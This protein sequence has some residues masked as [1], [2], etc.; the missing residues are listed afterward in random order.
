MKKAFA[1]FGGSK[2]KKDQGSAEDVQ[3]IQ[4]PSRQ[5]PQLQQ[6]QQA[7][8]APPQQHFKQQPQEQQFQQQ[9]GY[10]AHDARP[11]SRD[12]DD[13]EPDE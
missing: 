12:Y 1:K 5:Q 3:H 11:D 10:S 13:A 9:N 6:P 2:T 8:P 4:Q 7:A